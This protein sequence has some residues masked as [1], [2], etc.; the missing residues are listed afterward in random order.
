MPTS[1]DYTTDL[2]KVKSSLISTALQ[3]RAD[4]KARTAILQ[5]PD[6]LEWYPLDSLMIE[7]EAWHYVVDSLQIDPK[8]VFCH[9]AV[10]R[11]NTTTSLYYRAMSGLSLKAVRDYVGA[12]EKLEIGNKGARLTDAK[13]HKMAQTFNLFIC[14]I[15]LNS[16]SWTL[17]NGHRMIIATMGIS[18]DGVNRN[19]IGAVAEERVRRFVVEWVLERDLLIAPALTVEE[20]D[21][22]LPSHCELTNGIAMDFSSEPDIAFRRDAELL[23]VVE[24]KGGIDPAGALERYGAAQKS[25]SDAVTRSPHCKN[26]YLTAVTT[27]ELVTRIQRD[28]LVERTYNII[29][30]LSDPEARESF[31]IEIFHHTLRIV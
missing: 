19:K 31:L 30:L 20:L 15:I 22:G 21:A 18:L 5:F 11:W 10:L 2:R 8:L 1:D 26:F 17:E 4:V 24:I 14:S 27:A 23:A 7:P 25:F 13:A 3:G 9:P 12:V 6:A 29:D 16:S 28:R